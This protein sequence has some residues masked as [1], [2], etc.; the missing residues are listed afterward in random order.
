MTEWNL[1]DYKTV[2]WDSLVVNWN[3]LNGRLISK[4]HLTSASKSNT[5]SLVSS[6]PFLEPTAHTSLVGLE[7]I[8][9]TTPPEPPESRATKSRINS[10]VLTSQ[11][12]TVPSSLLVTT[13]LLLNWRQVTADWCLF[14]PVRVCRQAPV[15]MSQIFTV[16]SALPDTRMLSLSSMPEVRDWWPMRACL[17]DP[18]ST[19]HTR[20]LVSRLPDTTCTPSNCRL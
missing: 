15:R 9:Q 18:V 10:P 7:R 20:M 8:L 6:V 5:R 13:N 19:S 3:F 12:L 17:Q 14:V 2:T 1:D 11:S 16:L 4:C